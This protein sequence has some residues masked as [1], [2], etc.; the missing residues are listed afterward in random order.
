[1]ALLDKTERT[2][3]CNDRINLTNSK[4]SCSGCHQQITGWRYIDQAMLTYDLETLEAL[5]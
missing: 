5:K 2:H 1:M 4:L 3:C